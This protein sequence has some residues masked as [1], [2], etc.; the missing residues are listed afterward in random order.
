MIFISSMSLTG[1]KIICKDIYKYENKIY[2]PKPAAYVYI[3]DG[4]I[5]IITKRYKNYNEVPKVNMPYTMYNN[6]IIN[7]G[8]L[9]DKPIKYNDMRHICESY[10]VKITTNIPNYLD[11][12]KTNNPCN[13]FFWFASRKLH[14]KNK[15]DNKIEDLPTV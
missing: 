2:G 13:A 8:Q 15:Y 6:V 5:E 12:D 4:N 11:Y 14:F 7:K 3:Y 9:L 1:M 10:Y